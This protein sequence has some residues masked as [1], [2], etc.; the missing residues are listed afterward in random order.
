M[1]SAA[2]AQRPAPAATWRP[3]ALGAF[4]DPRR[5]VMSR[6]AAAAAVSIALLAPVFA[7]VAALFAQLEKDRHPVQPPAGPL[8]CAGPRLS[9]RGLRCA[10]G[11]A[12]R[13]LGTRCVPRGAPI[14]KA[15]RAVD[16]SAAD[17]IVGTRPRSVDGCLKA[18]DAYEQAA[19]AETTREARAIYQVRAADALCCAMR[20][21]SN[22]NIPLIDG[23]LDTPEHKR[24]WCRRLMPSRPHPPPAR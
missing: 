21:R 20:I 6:H 16:T 23:T 13:A 17:R 1:T 3:T 5:R 18:A 19:A 11:C 4:P 9:W 24:F 2:E 14:P 15:A 8:K 12:P 22:G 10:E 7:L